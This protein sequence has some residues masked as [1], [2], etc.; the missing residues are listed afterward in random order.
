MN[1]TYLWE[2]EYTDQFEEWWNTL[3]EDDQENVATVVAKLRE[4]GPMLGRPFV[5]T[6]TGSRYANL[7]ELRPQEGNLRV[8]FAFDPQR[9]AILLFGGDKT[10][11]WKRWYHKAIPVA[12]TLY[13]QHLKTLRREGG[14]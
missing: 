4:H 1:Y 3:S 10:N 7:K 9:T 2:V 5:D 14:T 11:N 6:I 8:L 12:D 13:E